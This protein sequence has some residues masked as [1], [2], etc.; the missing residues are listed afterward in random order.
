MTKR[1]SRITCIVIAYAAVVVLSTEG[2]WLT[3]AFILGLALGYA[4]A[5]MEEG[6]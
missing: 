5:A 6:V 3:P 2:G 4:I 1:S